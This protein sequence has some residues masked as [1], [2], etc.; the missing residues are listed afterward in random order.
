MFVGV[1]N[2]K[3][4]RLGKILNKMLEQNYGM[5]NVATD[6]DLFQFKGETGSQV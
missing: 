2:L 5:E 4:A 1:Q 6:L 3:E